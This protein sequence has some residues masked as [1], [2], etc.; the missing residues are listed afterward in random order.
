MARAVASRPLLPV[1]DRRT[2]AALASSRSGG[3]LSI[4][5]SCPTMYGFIRDLT[6]R[7]LVGAALARFLRLPTRGHGR[8]GRQ[9]PA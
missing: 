5:R 1:L 4:W 3:D 6:D 2:E 8:H 7:G 9:R